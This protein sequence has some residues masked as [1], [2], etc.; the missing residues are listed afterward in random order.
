MQNTYP[1]ADTV[2]ARVVDLI[3]RIARLLEPGEELPLDREL[4]DAG[5]DS[6]GLLELITDLEMEF[7]IAIPDEMLTRETFQSARTVAELVRGI[8][9]GAST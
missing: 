8:L 4:L 2:Q 3:R 6:F 1:D 9:A 5:V 7:D